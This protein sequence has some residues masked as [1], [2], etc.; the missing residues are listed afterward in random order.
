MEL[1]TPTV[2]PDPRLFAAL[3][4]ETRLR[5]VD[6]LRA[7]PALSTSAL[8]SGTSIT[9]QAVTKHLEVLA[10]VGLVSDVRRGR[11]RIWSLE[12]APLRDVAAWVEAFRA[13]WEARFDRLDTFLRD[14]DPGDDR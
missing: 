10:D 7:M 11:E 14:T 4:D 5:L 6:R 1:Q 3:G 13:I 12:A 8:A 2:R 9:R